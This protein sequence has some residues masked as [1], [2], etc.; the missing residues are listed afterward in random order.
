MSAFVVNKSHIDVLV[1]YAMRPNGFHGPTSYWWNGETHMITDRDQVGNLLLAENVRSVNARYDDHEPVPTYSYRMP[2]RAY[3][4]VEVIKAC[5]CLKYQSCETDDYRE[6][7][8]YAALNAIREK[9]IHAL[10]GYDDAD[11]EIEDSNRN[12]ESLTIVS[13]RFDEELHR[14]IEIIFSAMAD[15]KT[16]DEA[17]QSAY[18][19]NGPTL[20]SLVRYIEKYSQKPIYQF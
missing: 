16:L 17:M 8:A 12:D 11:W 3:S 1:W 10:A 9:A 15:G 7:E 13:E 18:I 14:H 2:T 5:D 6:T 4:E 20:E 19:K